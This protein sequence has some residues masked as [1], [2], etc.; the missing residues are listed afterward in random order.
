MVRQDVDVRPFDTLPL[1]KE[2]WLQ[3]AGADHSF[4][5][6]SQ[7]REARLQMKLMLL[8]LSPC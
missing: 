8:Q 1:S 6:H 4:R 3:A 2:N 7:R 5:R